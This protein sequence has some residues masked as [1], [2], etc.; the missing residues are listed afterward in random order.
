MLFPADHQPDGFV[1]RSAGFVPWGL[2]NN[3]GVEIGLTGYYGQKA[4]RSFGHEYRLKQGSGILTSCVATME[5]RMGQHRSFALADFPGPNWLNMRLMR[6]DLF[7]ATRKI[8]W[9]DTWGRVDFQQMVYGV[10]NDHDSECLSSVKLGPRLDDLFEITGPLDCI[11]LP[12]SIL[13]G[14]ASYAWL[15]SEKATTF[16]LP[17]RPGEPA[18]IH[19][20]VVFPVV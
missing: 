2:V 18:H 8:F 11:I 20:R 10:A 3:E 4:L 15:L 16:T 19:D 1:I 14:G 12:P 7:E 6:K 9:P 17:D 13:T 5:S